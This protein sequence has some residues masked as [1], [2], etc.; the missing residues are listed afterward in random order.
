VAGQVYS[1]GVL[2]PLLVERDGEPLPVA[3]GHQRTL[4]ALLL[5]G[6]QPIA[7]DRLIDELWGESPPATAGKALSV[8]L[9]RLR[10][11]L[12]EVISFSA[13]AY[14]LDA[15][16]F[17]LDAE[18]FRALVASARTAVE[19]E[20]RRDLF[21]EALELFRG[22]PLAGIESDGLVAR[23]R[24]T[25]E[26]ERL[27]AVIARVD[28]ELDLGAGAELVVELEGLLDGD[29]YEERIWGQLM[30]ALARCG[31]QA[32]ALDTYQRVRRLLAYELGIEP[33]Q[34]LA[35]I[36]AAI[37][38][39]GDGWLSGVV[40]VT[41]V[42][43]TMA[44]AAVEGR[45]AAPMSVPRPLGSL[46]GRSDELAE[47]SALLADRELRLLT[48]IGGGGVG[49]TRLALE[50]AQRLEERFA[51]GA[52]FVDLG[53]LGDPRLLMTEVAAALGARDGVAPPPVERLGQ[54]LASR[55]MLLVLDNFEH[56]LPAAAAVAALLEAAP[57]VQVIVTSRAPLRL[58]G[59]QLFEVEPLALPA[60][61]NPAAAVASPATELFL[62]RGRAIDRRL[63]SDPDSM[64]LI[65]SICR[66]VDGLPLGI[67]L[68]A[69][70]LRVLTLAQL[71]LSLQ[72]PLSLSAQVP[73]DL[74]DR[75]QTLEQTIRWSFNLLTPGARALLLAAGVFRGGFRIEALAAVAQ[76]APQADLA[77]LLDAS[78]VRRDHDTPRF[79]L[80]ELVRAFVIAESES[81]GVRAELLR[82]HRVHFC[83][84]ADA[85]GEE[86]QDGDPRGTLAEQLRPEQA[87]LRAAL[88]DAFAA[89]DR[90]S[91]LG[92][93]RGMRALWYTGWLVQEGQDV[94]GRVLDRFD[95]EPD[96]ELLLLR[97][98]SFL[99]GV[100]SH[101]HAQGAFTERLARRAQELD[102][103]PSLAIGLANL[104]ALAQN[105]QDRERV[106]AL[107]PRLLEAFEGDLPARIR[108]FLSYTLAVCDYIDGDIASACERAAEGARLSVEVDHAYTLAAT[109]LLGLMFCSIRDGELSRADL[110]AGFATL[111]LAPIRP[112]A[113]LA[114]WLVARYAAA[115]D[116][117]AAIRWLAEA[118]HVYRGLD[119]EMW[120][121]S[122]VREQTMRALGIDTVALPQSPDA[123]YLVTLAAAGAWL[124]AREPDEVA[125][126]C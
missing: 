63:Q 68:A 125:K 71:E 98:A 114:L 53:Q 112:L 6:D 107:K 100:S 86:L 117:D 94:I 46:I 12:G 27:E 89:G 5:A 49:K 123:D 113:P 23:W 97:S 47:L 91:A 56:L 11:Q 13:G 31:R 35:R 118:E 32:D 105:D 38:D 52:T 4:L 119:A 120:P 111:R 108:A 43:P 110:T 21:A 15:G 72:R 33:G 76:R 102:D 50:L 17:E 48:L 82:R 101:V 28:C 93:V 88:D 45:R 64:R 14:R 9:S 22:E 103:P 79:G 77:E 70:Q 44:E 80:L 122:D 92:L 2:G 29:P 124:D 39:G 1:F 62:E 8:F 74:P 61:Q 81:G 40:P 3:S 83:L 75:Q 55:E 90:E 116:R 54:Q 96:D 69:A 106:S 126:L 37:L 34:S 20:L 57:A 87:N 30:V 16:D 10:A 59:E 7:R 41:V 78:L 36:Q 85:V 115:F 18:R 109:S 19:P 42:V 65:A 95:L 84:I 73:R 26:Q 121:E 66:Q 60:E 99:D 24:R 25:L 104:A 67:E 58:R 51:D